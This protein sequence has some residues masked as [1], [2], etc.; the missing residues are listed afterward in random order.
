MIGKQWMISPEAIAAFFDGKKAKTEPDHHRAPGL[1]QKNVCSQPPNTIRALSFFSGAMGLDLGLEQAGIEV[2]LACE[3]DGPCRKTIAAN[4]P[5]LAL[6]GDIR[7]YS[8]SQIREYAGLSMNDE[9]D[10]VVGGPPCQAFS[11]AGARKG[12][13]DERGNVFQ[14]PRLDSR[15]A[16]IRC[17]RKCSRPI[18]TPPAPTSALRRV[19]LRRLNMTNNPEAS[20]S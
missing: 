5:N 12:L 6:I 16:P 14:V 1:M 19:I 4:K 11:T 13:D 18:V 9:V 3:N 2:L 8:S 10:L 17:H 15:T 7:D 20:C